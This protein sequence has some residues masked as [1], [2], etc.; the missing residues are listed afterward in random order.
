ML[1]GHFTSSQCINAEGR[2][3]SVERAPLGYPPNGTRT[4]MSNAVARNYSKRRY[5]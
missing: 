2:Y 3:R 4:I 5:D 1:A